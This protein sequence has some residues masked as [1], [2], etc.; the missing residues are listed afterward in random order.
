MD[1]LVQ[2]VIYLLFCQVLSKKAVISLTTEC[3][4]HLCRITSAI[5]CQSTLRN[6]FPSPVAA[7]KLYSEV[8]LLKGP[9]CCFG[10]LQAQE[11]RHVI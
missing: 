6:S 2:A 9:C 5:F 8:F 7:S 11:I 4:S 3:I 10:C 1:C